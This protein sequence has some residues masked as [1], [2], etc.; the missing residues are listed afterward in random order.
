M[1][2]TQER[3]EPGAGIRGEIPAAQTQAAPQLQTGKKKPTTFVSRHQSRE[4]MKQPNRSPRCESGTFACRIFSTLSKGNVRYKRLTSKQLLRGWET[5]EK[6]F[7][8]GYSGTRYAAV[9]KNALITWVAMVAFTS[10]S[11]KAMMLTYNCTI[12]DPYSQLPTT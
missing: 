11:D 7:P 6:R 4:P 2:G 5:G 12:A 3:A 8:R 10:Q 9:Q 1:L